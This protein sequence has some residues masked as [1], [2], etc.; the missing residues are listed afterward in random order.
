MTISPIYPCLMRVAFNHFEWPKLGSSPE[1][2]FNLG[3]QIRGI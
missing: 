2:L 1:L 3:V